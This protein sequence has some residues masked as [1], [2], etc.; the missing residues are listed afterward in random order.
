[1]QHALHARQQLIQNVSH[2]L[3]TPLGVV[4]GY[5]GLLE[6]GELGPVSPDQKQALTIMLKHEEQLRLMV[7]RLVDLR[8]VEAAQLCRQPIDVADWLAVVLRPWHKRAMLTDHP[9]QVELDLPGLQPAWSADGE[10]LKQ[11]LDNLLDNAFKFSRPGTSIRVVAKIDRATVLFGVQD[12]GVG[13]APDQLDQVFE[14]FYQVDGSTTRRFGGMGIGLALCKEIVE[15]HSGRIWAESAGEG[16]GSTFW[17]ALPLS[18]SWGG[19]LD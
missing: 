6:E 17:C 12:T 1:L 3:R 14:R 16:Y 8:S 5:T 2:E 4:Y 15:A 9:F 18:A 13:L 10:L 19:D 7:D 11:V